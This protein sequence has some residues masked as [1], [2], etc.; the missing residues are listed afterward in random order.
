MCYISIYS[1]VNPLNF[2]KYFMCN[3][4]MIVTY[5]LQNV[6]MDLLM[7]LLCIRRTH[8]NIGILLLTSMK[9]I[10]VKAV[11]INYHAKYEYFFL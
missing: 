10:Q 5:Y 6:L 1:T 7:Y 3:L 4:Y 2:H 9:Y 11:F 8:V